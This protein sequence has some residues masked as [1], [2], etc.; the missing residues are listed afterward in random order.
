[1]GICWH[2]HW[3]LP[4]PVADIFRK[5]VAR[6]GG[7]GHALYYGPAHIVWDDENF[8]DRSVNWC[9]DQARNHRQDYPWRTD[10]ECAIAAWSL[11]RLLEIPEEIR[12]APEDYDGEHPENYPPPAGMEM[13]RV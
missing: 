9:L 10:E 7:D 8:E 13:V 4:K 12:C 11:E 5:A 1:M 6:L 3:G 2:C